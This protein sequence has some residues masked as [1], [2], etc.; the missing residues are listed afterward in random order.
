MEVTF[1]RAKFT[2]RI[3]A[4]MVDLFCMAVTALLLVLAAR[5]LVGMAPFYNDASNKI[6]EVQLSSHIYTQDEKGD[7]LLLSEFYSPENEDECKEYNV[8]LDKALKDFYSDPAFFDQSDENSGLAIYINLRLDTGHFIYTDDSHSDVAPK[9]D[10]LA[11]TIYKDYTKIMKEDAIKYIAKNADY[12]NSIRTLNLSF[13]FLML[14]TP[15]VISVT[16]FEYIIPLCLRRGRKTLGKLAFKLGVVDMQGLSPSFWRFTARFA[17]FLIVEVL[18]SIVAFLIPLIVT[19][20]MFAFSKSAQSFHDY[21]AGTYVVNCEN[22]RIFM[23]KKEY[24]DAKKEA[25]EFELK[26]DMVDLK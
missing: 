24:L 11:S 2:H 9:D 16:L 7:T 23:N 1:D 19:I 10:V 15:I 6:K 3:F 26:S 21:V 22:A 5:Q 13:I 12:I 4:F 25:E 18:L 14:L 8:N 17:L 20:S